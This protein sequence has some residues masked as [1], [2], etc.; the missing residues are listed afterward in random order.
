VDD[1]VAVTVTA[2]GLGWL[3]YF[4]EFDYHTAMFE[5]EEQFNNDNL[6]IRVALFQLNNQALMTEFNHRHRIDGGRAAFPA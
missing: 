1:A 5:S 4:K 3:K 6:A 2:Q